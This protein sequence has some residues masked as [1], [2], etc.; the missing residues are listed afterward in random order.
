MSDFINYSG[1]SLDA[2]KSFKVSNNDADYKDLSVDDIKKKLK[3]FEEKSA[4][5]ATDSDKTA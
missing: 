5:N 2:A 4:N 3:L 1:K